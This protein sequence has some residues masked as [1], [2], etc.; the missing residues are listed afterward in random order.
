VFIGVRLIAVRADLVRTEH[1]GGEPLV[2]ACRLS[3]S[4]DRWVSLRATRHRLR[5]LRSTRTLAAR[6]WPQGM[7]ICTSPHDGASGASTSLTPTA[8]T[9]FLLDLR[10]ARV[11]L[12]RAV[13]A[14][15]AARAARFATPERLRPASWTAGSRPAP[16]GVELRRYRRRP[17]G[18]H[19]KR[20]PLRWRLNLGRRTLS[21]SVAD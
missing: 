15:R 8:V 3:T 13:A 17:G 18:L 4:P 19:G 10:R 9:T 5:T 12:S 11:V 21:P 1:R 6:C 16:A 2:G 7:R 20:Y 14:W